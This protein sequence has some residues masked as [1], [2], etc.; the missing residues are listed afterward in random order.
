MKI[1]LLLLVFMFLYLDRAV[2]LMTIFDHDLIT[3]VKFLTVIVLIV[4]LHF[5]LLVCTSEHI[6][7]K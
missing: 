3:F 1:C 5:Y 6:L 7:F 2:L 4:L